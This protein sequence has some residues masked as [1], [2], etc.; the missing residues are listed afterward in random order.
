LQDAARPRRQDNHD[1][2]EKRDHDQRAR[3]ARDLEHTYFRVTQGEYF[4]RQSREARA[5]EYVRMA[6]RLYQQARVAYDA[7]DL[8]R[9]RRLAGAAKEVINSL[10]NLAQAAVPVPEPPSL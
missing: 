4:A 3:T 1:A 2:G 8:R 9:A 5:P 6:Q 10:E 7:G